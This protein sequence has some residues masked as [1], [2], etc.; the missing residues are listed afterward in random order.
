MP[1]AKIDFGN[2]TLPPGNIAPEN[3]VNLFKNLISINLSNAKIMSVSVPGSSTLTELYV[4]NSSITELTLQDQPLLTNLNFTGCKSLKR[5][6][7]R[8]VTQLQTVTLGAEC[9]SLT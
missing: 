1:Q 4:A 9:V 6:T 8:N 5:L 7:L 2:I 3:Y